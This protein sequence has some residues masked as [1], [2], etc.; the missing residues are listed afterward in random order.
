MREIKYLVVHCDA[1]RP[2]N[3]FDIEDIRRMHMN[4]P[5]YWNDIGYHW[6]IK[7]DGTLQKGRDESIQGA[8]VRDYNRYSIGI[9]MAGGLNQETFVPEDNFTE[10]QYVTL[11]GLLLDSTSKYPNAKV[12]GH[13]DFHGVAKACPCYDVIPWWEN[14]L[15]ELDAEIDE[16]DLIDVPWEITYKYNYIIAS[17]EPIVFLEEYNVITGQK[18]IYLAEVK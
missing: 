1:S 9:C 8:H 11:T 18:P 4:K 16:D 10:A 3:D 12:Q 5:N 7:R 15:A 14:V 2:S 17:D 13:R 6:F